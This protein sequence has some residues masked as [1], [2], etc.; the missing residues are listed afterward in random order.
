MV[1]CGV[2]CGVVYCGEVESWVCGVVSVMSV[3]RRDVEE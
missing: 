2:V 3:M 1:W